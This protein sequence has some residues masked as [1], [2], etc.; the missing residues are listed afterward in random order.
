[1]KIALAARFSAQRNAY[2]VRVMLET[3][4]EWRSSV[5]RTAANVNLTGDI[6]TFLRMLGCC[7]ARTLGWTS[8]V[9]KTTHTPE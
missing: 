9:A 7:E 2:A 6:P 3:A 1:M 8:P 4:A 5:R